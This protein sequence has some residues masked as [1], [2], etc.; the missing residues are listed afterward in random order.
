M[1]T[2]RGE[3]H[4]GGPDHTGPSQ[5]SIPSPP[6]LDFTGP[7]AQPLEGAGKRPLTLKLVTGSGDERHAAAVAA[8]LP[9]PP[10]PPVEAPDPPAVRPPRPTTP[11][12]RTKRRA[13]RRTVLLG[14]GSALAVSVITIGVF[15]AVSAGSSHPAATP[16]PAAPSTSAPGVRFGRPTPPGWSDR[17]AWSA[18][19]AVGTHPALA[20]GLVALITADRHLQLRYGSTGAI[21]WTTPAPLLATATGSPAIAQID[22]HQ[23]IVIS[24]DPTTQGQ[25]SLLLWQVDGD[26]TTPTHITLPANAQ[27]SY[28]GDTLL[29]T[30][31]DGSAS[32]VA[33]GQLITVPLPAKAVAMAVDTTGTGA[34]SPT[35]I[36]G[37][38]AGTWWRA[39]LA[40]S[41]TQIHPA[42]PAGAD[43]V[44]RIAAAGHGTVT[45]VWSTK[46]GGQ[47]I[48]ALHDAVTGRILATAAAPADQ[49]HT[50]VWLRGNDNT[51]AALGP[52]TFD[53]QH[54]TATAHPG[55][56]PLSVAGTVVYGQI[57]GHLAAI[58]ASPGTSTASPVDVPQGTAV[59]W[60]LAAGD[61]AIVADRTTAGISLYAL[62]PAGS[63]TTS[64]APTPGGTP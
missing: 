5:Q 19:I 28:A 41:P 63:N 34:T 42:K 52:V 2:S 30:G 15:T 18:P 17:V 14:A 10:A 6:T 31:A 13:D 54:N 29:V 36:A 64:T 60:G 32:L 35:V 48:A 45:L 61:R 47:E 49:L 22:G 4:S 40:S 58:A 38:P 53:L 37:T 1:T 27:I 8:R 59:P 26:G 23:T 21:V 16:R 55:F 9:P 11:R 44:T 62:L 20:S 7:A 51:A 43:Q 33:N 50:P 25:G 39:S 24:S 3:E 57:S 56:A 12:L 46:K